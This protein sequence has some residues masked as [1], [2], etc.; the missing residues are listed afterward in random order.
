M[1]TVM[2]IANDISYEDIFSYQ[3]QDRLNPG[4]LII[5]ISGSGNSKN[6]IKAVN[7][8][9]S[10]GNTIIGLTGFD[11]GRLMQLA[12][13][14]LHAPIDN[15]QITEDIHLLFNH[16]LVSVLSNFLS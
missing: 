3:L 4:D 2:A 13:I 16:L 14:N 11:G 6:I 5:A 10:C 9:K 15:M 12:D 8:V 7:Y 1:A